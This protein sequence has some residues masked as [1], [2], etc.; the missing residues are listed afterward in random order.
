MPIQS[1]WPVNELGEIVS[2]NGTGSNKIVGSVSE[3]YVPVDDKGRVK[4]VNVGDYLTSKNPLSVDGKFC[5]YQT[6]STLSGTMATLGGSKVVRYAPNRTG[7]SSI[8]SCPD[9]LSNVIRCYGDVTQVHAQIPLSPTIDCTTVRNIGIWARASKRVDG[10][11]GSYARVWVTKDAAG[12]PDFGNQNSFSQHSFVV[13]ADGKW[14]LIVLPSS[15][16]SGWGGQGMYIPGTGNTAAWLRVG[17]PP[18]SAGQE[19][20]PVMAADDFVEF[21][22]FVI[23]VRGSRAL[24]QFGLMMVKVN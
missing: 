24:F 4:F 14:R 9:K 11:E 13:P 21:G 6:V 15:P 3:E 8:G 22:S 17:V 5:S 1:G 7:T 10:E 20:R 16:D 12:S 23:N 2:V 18:L 19:E